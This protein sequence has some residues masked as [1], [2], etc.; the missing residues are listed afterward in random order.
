MVAEQQA[1]VSLGPMVLLQWPYQAFLLFH[2]QGQSYDPSTKE[3]IDYAQSPPHFCTLSLIVT[4]WLY[5]SMDLRKIQR[6]FHHEDSTVGTSIQFVM[7]I[8]I[9][10]KILNWD[11]NPMELTTA[12]DGAYLICGYLN[13][14]CHFNAISN[15]P[16]EY[17]CDPSYDITS[18][19]DRCNEIC[20]VV[21]YFPSTGIFYSPWF[22]S[23]TSHLW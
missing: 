10:E 13:P 22:V 6:I 12:D 17:S 1:R 9:K 2:A 5:T 21:L 8:S 4:T 23:D 3:R 15:K 18:M 20:T 16:T 7:Y 11:I 19:N 14:N